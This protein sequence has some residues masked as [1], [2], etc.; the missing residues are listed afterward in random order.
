MHAP[1]KRRSISITDFL[2]HAHVQRMATV[3]READGCETDLRL[4]IGV[5]T[6][7]KVLNGLPSKFTNAFPKPQHIAKIFRTPEPQMVGHQRHILHFADY[8]HATTLDDLLRARE[9]AGPELN[10]IQFDM[11][12]PNPTMLSQLQ[13]V[14]LADRKATLPIILQI[15]SVMFQW[16]QGNP[17]KL[18]RRLWGNYNGLIDTI[19]FD[20]SAGNG[21]PLQADLF[22]PFFDLFRERWPE[23]NLA[24][25]GGLGPDTLNLLEPLRSY[26]PNL[27][28]DA[29]S[30]LRPSRNARDPIDWDYAAT[31]LRKAIRLL[32]PPSD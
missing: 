27:S 31:Y 6:S 19:L 25:A 8:E 12:W 10:G 18:L 9:F 21:A 1:Q 4:D 23:L 5:M 13:S 17:R 20:L 14:F 15:N 26:F 30:N 3:F 16:A 29:Q 32:A 24:V 7:R 11:I 2:E 22:I 28:I